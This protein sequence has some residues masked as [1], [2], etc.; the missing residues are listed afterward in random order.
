MCALLLMYWYHTRGYV[1]I[2]FIGQ[3]YSIS[4]LR[5]VQKIKVL[6]LEKP[7]QFL[8]QETG[9]QIYKEPEQFLFQAVGN[10]VYSVLGWSGSGT[11]V[12]DSDL[13]L[14]GKG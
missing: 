11:Q 13:A 10:K 9:N 5:S 3:G 2:C 6:A 1:L 12:L 7:E 14:V 8:F 4:E